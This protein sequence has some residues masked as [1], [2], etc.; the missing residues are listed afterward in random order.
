MSQEIP[1]YEADER[2]NNIVL[3]LLPLSALESEAI[4]E[5]FFSNLVG[6]VQI[7]NMLPYIVTLSNSIGS[8]N[9]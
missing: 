4:E 1:A 8:L 9:C 6:Q 2:F 7:D 3:N 5:L